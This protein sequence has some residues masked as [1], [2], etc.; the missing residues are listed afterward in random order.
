MKLDYGVGIIGLHWVVQIMHLPAYRSAQYRLVAAAENMPE[1]IEQVKSK[2]YKI[3][4]YLDNWPDLVRLPEVEVIDCSFGHNIARQAKRLEVVHACAEAKKHLMIHKPAA[5]TLSLAE[6]MARVAD[7]AGIHLAVNQNCRYN[8]ANY[9]VKHLLTP[10]RAGK[11][12][13]IELQNYWTG[14][15][16]DPNNNKAAWIAHTVHHADLIRWW[17][18]S[19]CVSVYAK[20]KANSSLTLYEFENG[21]VVYHMENHSGV[22]EHDTT[23]RIQAERAIIKA[24]HNWNWHYP[25]SKGRDFVN[26]FVDRREPAVEIPLPEHIYEPVWSDI[27]HYIPHSGPYYD[28][29]APVAGMM[30]SMGALMQG[31]AE[32]RAPENS[33]HR[34]IEVLRMCMAAE[35]SG[36]TGKPMNPKDVPSDYSSD[37]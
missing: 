13:I 3:G 9:A 35:I 17:V 32:N 5:V 19:P 11:P 30:G 31:V 25:S 7:Q 23:M 6:E 29:G 15:F 28:L 21:V 20:T 8:P 33:I 14:N 27:N 1:K 2:G 34:G 36:S 10:E 24:G 4:K 12:V 16:P 26:V 18:D 37:R 22:L